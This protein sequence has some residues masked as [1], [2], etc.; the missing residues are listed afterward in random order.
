MSPPLY[1]RIHILS[2]SAFSL[3][4]YLQATAMAKYERKGNAMRR[5]NPPFNGKQFVL[6]KNTGEIHDLDNETPN[7][8]IDEIKPEH[9]INCVD[10]INASIR[11]RAFHCLHSVH[12]LI[13]TTSH[14]L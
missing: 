2:F 8:K 6:N 1:S 5:Y 9:V 14:E 12:F 3:I 13:P 4:L 10:Y 11:A 7:C